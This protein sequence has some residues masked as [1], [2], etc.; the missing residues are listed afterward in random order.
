M[1]A[2]GHPGAQELE[3]APVARDTTTTTA[4]IEMIAAVQ[5]E[6]QDGPVL[7]TSKTAVESVV[8]EGLRLAAGQGQRR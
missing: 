3:G 4:E 1:S 6:P 5:R 2:A 8:A 7:G